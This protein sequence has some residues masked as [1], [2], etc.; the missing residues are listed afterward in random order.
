MPR[1]KSGIKRPSRG[2]EG[3]N[4][5]KN[6]VRCVLE[7]GQS[8]RNAAKLHGVSKSTL[9][10]HLTKHKESENETFKYTGSNAVWRVFSDEDE[11]QLVDYLVAGSRMHYGLS[12]KQVK[13][14][15]YE[16]AVA[17]KKRYPSSWDISKQAGKQ[18]YA[19]F[20]SRHKE[21]ISLRKPQATSLSRS[22]SFNKHNVETFFGKLKDLIK[23]YDFTAEHIYNLDESGIS[24]VHSPEKV[25]APKGSK[26]VGSMTSGERG[27]LV[28]I[29]A[30][31]NALGNTVPPMMIFPRVRFKEA[32]LNGAPPGTIGG[33]NASGWSNADKFL[34][35]LNHFIRFVK[36][37]K[38]RP[39]LLILDNHDSHLSVDAIQLAKDS[40][41]VMLT[42]PPHTSHKLQPLDRSVF[43]PFKKYYN[44]ACG[45]WMLE[46]GGRPLTIMQLAKCTGKAYPHAF[47]PSNIQSGFRVS[48]I[49]PLDENIFGDDEFMSSLV[50]DRPL[51][52][53]TVSE[54]EDL[55][56]EDMP[57]NPPTKQKEPHSEVVKHRPTPNKELPATTSEPVSPYDVRPFPKAPPRK[58]A[59]GGRKPGRCRVVTDTPEKNEIEAAAAAR[60]RKTT[61]DLNK[62]V[63][64]KLK[65][66]AKTP[67]PKAKR[68]KNSC[69]DQVSSSEDSDNSVSV[70]D[71][72]DLEV[73]PIDWEDSGPSEDKKVACS[74]NQKEPILVGDFCLV[75]VAGK[76]RILNFVVEIVQA[77][78]DDL[79][80]KYLKRMG[81][82]NS[83]YYDKQNLYDLLKSDVVMKLDNPVTT[84]GTERQCMLLA[85]VTNFDGYII[86]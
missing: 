66:P 60:I 36:P 69:W 39:V 46:N 28:T 6:A 49:W 31:A 47:T 15:A 82:T 61:K 33:A 86:S 12:T 73:E 64:T 42:F 84:G 13:V 52:Q 67:R 16:F 68:R 78:G 5:L 57:I 1:S 76:K 32:M 63:K 62:E 37:S 21:T 27:T 19:S 20:M 50:T 17:N 24:T 45:E 44:T 2:E 54:E 74:F 41:V 4:N 23:K 51:N 65:V 7:D 71:L 9:M 26:Q 83:F 10:R 34:D 43:G 79:I 81:Q 25:V 80:V 77:N 75:K 72:S 11:V 56:D 30:C 22:T 14:L 70:I 59:K 35:Y 3:I 48:G 18:F 58:S 40:G 29:I 55:P 53:A 38:E 8:L 85:F